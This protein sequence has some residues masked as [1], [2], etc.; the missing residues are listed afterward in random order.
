MCRCVWHA[1][2]TMLDS[3]HEPGPVNADTA[4]VP[5]SP[6]GSPSIFANGVNSL[7]NSPQPKSGINWGI[8]PYR[9]DNPEAYLCS[10]PSRTEP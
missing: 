1:H 8:C 7:G 5:G 3:T 9:W 4:G 6:W 2:I 10:L